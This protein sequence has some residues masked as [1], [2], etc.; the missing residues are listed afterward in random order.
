LAQPGERDLRAADA[1]LG[2]DLAGG[3]RRL[4]HARDGGGRHGLDPA[5]STLELAIE[6]LR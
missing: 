1:A 3:D 2:G 6:G 4:L 5:A